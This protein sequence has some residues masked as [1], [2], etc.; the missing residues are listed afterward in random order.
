MTLAAPSRN[1]I[2]TDGRGDVDTTKTT[3]LRG[4]I[5]IRDGVGRVPNGRY[6]TTV[7]RRRIKVPPTINLGHVC[8]E[9]EISRGVWKVAC[10]VPSRAQCVFP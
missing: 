5:R 10:G 6:R 1:K 8:L 2:A 3:Y 7:A 9:R 4:Y